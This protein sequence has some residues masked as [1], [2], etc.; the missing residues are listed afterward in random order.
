LLEIFLLIGVRAREADRDGGTRI[1]GHDGDAT[2][3]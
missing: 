2:P 1:V 3:L